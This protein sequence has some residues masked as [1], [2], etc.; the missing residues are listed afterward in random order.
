MVG[1]R[2]GAPENIGRFK[3]LLVLRTTLKMRPISRQNRSYYMSTCT[4]WNNIN[5]EY[6]DDFGPIAR[7]GVIH[8]QFETIHPFL[9]GNGRMGRILIIIY[10]LDKGVISSPAFFISEEL[11]RSKHKYYALLNG[12]RLDKPK[13]K[14]WLTFFL[15]ASIKQAEKYIE[16]LTA[17]ESLYN[18]LSE[19]AKSENIKKDAILFIFRTPVFTIKRMQDELEVSY[20]TARRYTSK[21][22]NGGK[23]YGDD[24]KRNKSYTFYDL[25]GIL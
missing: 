17:V 8:G 2:I 1:A 15:D 20:N 24:K 13:W 9:D 18:D 14:E 7:A 16:K 4:I 19:F 23:I 10:L 25:I 22:E 11:E 21:L 5:D 3:T 12:L 6:E